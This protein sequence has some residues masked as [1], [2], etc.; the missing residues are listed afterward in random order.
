MGREEERGDQKKEK[1]LSQ[2]KH[3]Q[4]TASP[5]RKSTRMDTFLLGARLCSACGM[6]NARRITRMAAR[7]FDAGAAQ[8][9]QGSALTTSHRHLV[10]PTTG[11]LRSNEVVS[12]SHLEGPRMKRGRGVSLLHQTVL[13]F[14]CA[15]SQLPQ[16]VRNMSKG[17]RTNQEIPPTALPIGSHTPQPLHPHSRLLPFPAIRPHSMQR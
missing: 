5:T 12:A 16:D 1:G 17:I 7:Y 8:V 9:A 3:R 13:A 2:I 10:I 15:L 11:V 6:S 14:A 4:R